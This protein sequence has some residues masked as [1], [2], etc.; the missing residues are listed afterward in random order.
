M[1]PTA[2]THAP[3]RDIP[4]EDVDKIFFPERG[5]AYTKARV[6]CKGCLDKDECLAI[7]LAFELDGEDLLG[8]WGGLSQRERKRLHE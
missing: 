5:N 4:K 8:M 6:V 7:A 2:L 3:C 1:F